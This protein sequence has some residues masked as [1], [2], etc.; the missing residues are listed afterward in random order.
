MYNVDLEIFERRKND[1]LQNRLHNKHNIRRF[2][3][4]KIL[5]LAGQKHVS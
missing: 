2:L 5:E 1:E 3:S 4:R